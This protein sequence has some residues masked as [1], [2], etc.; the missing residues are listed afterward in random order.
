MRSKT[1][2]GHR[3]QALNSMLVHVELARYDIEIMMKMVSTGEGQRYSLDK[4]KEFDLRIAWI[5]NQI[6]LC[7]LELGINFDG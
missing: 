7:E 1:S 3:L 4:L 6:A 2:S 5:N